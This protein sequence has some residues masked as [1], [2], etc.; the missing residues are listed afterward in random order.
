MSLKLQVCLGTLQGLPK[1][2]FSIFF[3]CSALLFSV[4][5]LSV[6]LAKSRE[7][8]LQYLRVLTH[9][10]NLIEFRLP[11]Y[12]SQKTFL[13]K[14]EWRNEITNFVGFFLELSVS[15]FSFFHFFFFPFISIFAVFVCKDFPTEVV[16]SA[17]ML[18]QNGE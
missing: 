7:Q 6:S 18:I 16:N 3:T 17:R 15:I 5:R 14:P 1:E 13:S 10:W 12:S 9:A 11:Q 4:A 8:T 2:F